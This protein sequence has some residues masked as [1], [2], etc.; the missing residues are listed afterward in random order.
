MSVP[1]RPF[2]LQIQSVALD[3]L[4]LRPLKAE[5]TVELLDDNKGPF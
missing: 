5:Q 1:I 3:R 2:L 4:N